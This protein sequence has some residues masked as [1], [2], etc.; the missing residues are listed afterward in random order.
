[1]SR[2]VEESE[3]GFRDLAGN[4][5]ALYK[6]SGR[7]TCQ[8]LC[9]TWRISLLFREGHVARSDREILG[10]EP[11]IHGSQMLESQRRLRMRS[12]PMRY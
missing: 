12:L 1:M 3:V 6:S 9:V 11:V 8:S 7:A 5:T 10:S 2:S 4:A